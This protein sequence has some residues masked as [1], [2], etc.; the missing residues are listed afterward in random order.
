MTLVQAGH[1]HF[2]HRCR[3]MVQT[4]PTVDNVLNWVNDRLG[5][6]NAG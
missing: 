3:V 5:A 1:R 6:Q 2:A 4:W